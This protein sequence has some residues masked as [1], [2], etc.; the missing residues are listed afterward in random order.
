[1]GASRNRLARRGWHAK[2]LAR[3]TSFGKPAAVIFAQ[4]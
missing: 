3:L 4:H 1:M 2:E